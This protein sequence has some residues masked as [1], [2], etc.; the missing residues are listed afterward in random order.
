MRRQGTIR[1]RT[2]ASGKV[3]FDAAVSLVVREGESGSRRRRLWK[4]GFRTQREAQAW[5]TR[6]VGAVDAGTFV[7]P[8]DEYLADFCQKWAENRL[9][10]SPRTR[11]GYETYVKNYVRPALGGVKLR[12]LTTDTLRSFYRAITCD[13]HAEKP[14]KCAEG[15]V[16]PATVNRVHSFLHAALETAVEDGKLGRNPATKKLRKEMVREEPPEFHP[17]TVE[18]ARSFLAYAK[19]DRMFA[20]YRLAVVSGLRR[21]ELAGLRWK[22]LD[23]EEEGMV[24]VRQT[25]NFLRGRAVFGPPKSRKSRRDVAIGAATVKALRAHRARQRFDRQRAGEA[26]RNDEADLVFVN[27]VGDHFHPDTLGKAFGRLVRDGGFRKVRLHDLRHGAVAIAASKG[28]NLST[29]S[30]RMGHS[31]VAFTWQRY[32]HLFADDNRK[33]GDLMDDAVDGVA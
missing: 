8:S 22:D 33:A 10:L 20:F 1:S 32:G 29:V 13:Q 5:I 23:L 18:E 3:V 30:A 15:R 9:G 6:T 25:L 11:D 12:N 24:R 17:W 31:S 7:K 2:L 14:H 27:E 19:D 4:R 28:E 26:W 16:S 21:A